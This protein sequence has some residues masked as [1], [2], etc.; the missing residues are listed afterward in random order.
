LKVI[1]STYIQLEHTRSASISLINI[2]LGIA[3]LHLQNLT[4]PNLTCGFFKDL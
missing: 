3:S 4:H 1:I 2:W